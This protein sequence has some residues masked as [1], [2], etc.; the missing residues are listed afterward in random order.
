MERSG[1]RVFVREWMGVNRAYST[2]RW[3]QRRN[4]HALDF[5]KSLHHQYSPELLDFR[6]RL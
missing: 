1:I 4:F 3:S 2:S 5:G 6:L